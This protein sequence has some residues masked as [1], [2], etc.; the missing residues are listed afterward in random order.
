MKSRISIFFLIGLLLF[1]LDYIFNTDDDSNVIYISDQEALSLISSWKNQVGR[2]PSDVELV[3]IIN[4]FIDE[5]ILYREAIKLNLDK[6]DRIIKR[7]LA[8][9]ITFLKKDSIKYSDQDL[10]NFYNANKIVYYVNDLYSFKHYYFS[11][12][13]DPIK[14]A[15]DAKASL[16]SKKIN[17]ISDPYIIGN[18]FSYSSKDEIIKN[19]GNEF[20]ESFLYLSLGQWSEPI[21]SEFGYHLV[22]IESYSKGFQPTYEQVKNKVI[23]D[24]LIKKKDEEVNRYLSDLKKDYEVIINPNLKF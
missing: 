20:F 13:K 3:K 14:R 16:E 19:F 2:D 18:E 7:R 8:Q 5:E 11:D 10:V 24:Y 1:A 15:L 12:N 22:Y 6:D 21:K 9:K 23:N 17:I 4:N